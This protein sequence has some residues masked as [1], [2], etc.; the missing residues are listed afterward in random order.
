MTARSSSAYFI[1]ALLHGSVVALILFFAYLANETSNEGPK[2][3]ELVAGAGDN[4]GATEA[5]A[6]GSP[7]GIKIDVP[8]EPTPAALAPAEPATP[9][10]VVPASV[11]P[12]PVAREEAPPVKLAPVSAHTPA[13]AKPKS[14]AIPNFSKALQR[15]ENRRAARLMAKYKKE[16]EAEQHRQQMSY[17]QY[18]KEHGAAQ[19][20]EGIA[21]GVV[22][23]SRANKTGGAGG[24]ALTR[25]QG[26]LLDAY[27]AL[28]KARIKENHVAPPDVSNQLTV[29]VSFYVAADG[30]ISR[31]RI[32]Q[33]S[34][35][36]AFDE[37]VLEAFAR[38]HSIGPRPDGRGDTEGLEYRMRDEEE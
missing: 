5:P 36:S 31:V 26:E 16:L 37:S 18:V 19:A 35:S 3:F 4:Y 14:D 20:S 17:D 7:G 9:E 10:P 33:S 13:K 21:Q 22:G 6:L 30:A 27:W 1:S 23:G 34:G 32:V 28:L 25:E 2:V 24:K 12:E 8:S 11:A 38:T 15:T 29:S